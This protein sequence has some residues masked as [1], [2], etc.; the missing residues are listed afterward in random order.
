MK[1]TMC[2][3]LALMVLL[4]AAPV[5]V[6]APPH[7]YLETIDK[8]R[9]ADGHTLPR[10][11]RFGWTLPYDL[12]VELADAW[13]YGL[14]FGGYA[15]AG[16]VARIQ[17]PDSIEAR[18]VKLATEQPERFPLQVILTRELPDTPKDHD[19]V[20]EPPSEDAELDEGDD[21]AAVA[22]QPAD[23]TFPV[24]QWTRT[25]DG[26]L[27]TVEKKQ[28]DGAVT[29]VPRKIWS[30]EMPQFI[31]EQAAELRA[32]PLRDLVDTG[33]RIAVVLNG[34]EYGIGVPGFHAK[35]WK[36]DPRIIEAKGD[37]SWYEYVSERKANMERTIAEAVRDAVPDRQLYIY[38]TTGGGTHRNRWGGWT[39]WSYGYEWMKPVSDL[40]S[41]EAYYKHFNSG[42]TGNRNMLKMILN[43]KGWEIR[44]GQPLTY[45]WLCA[46]WPRGNTEKNPEAGLGD[47]QRYMGFVKC[48][49]VTGMV[50]ANAGYYAYPKGGFNADIDL[51]NPPHWLR[52]MVVL[53]RVHAL[54]SHVDEMV[55]E[56]ELLPG[57]NRHAWSKE[58]PAYEFPTG[59]P[60]ARVIV[61]K[62][63][64]SGRW[65]IATWAAGG[66]AR[67]V[68]VDVPQLGALTLLARPVG[69]VYL[70]TRK[71]D[72]AVLTQLDPD[73]DLPSAQV[74]EILEKMTP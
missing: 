34:G 10:L 8:P 70:V 11:T 25:A 60:D 56:G 63:Q 74:T 44:L 43:A 71:N 36:Q 40:A 9:F 51:E 38:Y 14:E 30:P 26:K 39:A 29:Q 37:R 20:A 5:T 7:A 27:V 33:A 72:N 48:L 13:G 68:T 31:V 61:R 50:G 42:W 24:D 6:A 17:N 64:A 73:P 4:A 35:F 46:G 18:V 67:E 52:Q 1:M 19:A 45:N 62:H 22:T 23:T 69:A 58:N 12:R 2:M 15:S 54:F 21:T 65:L 28:G 57:P 41:D 47:L 49:Y 59:D 3:K 32:E 55:R 16:K 53:A 66:E